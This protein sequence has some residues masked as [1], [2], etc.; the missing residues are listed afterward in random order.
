ML[1]DLIKDIPGINPCEIGEGRKHSYWLY[2]WSIDESKFGVSTAEFCAILG[3][4]GIPAGAGYIGKPIYDYEFLRDR[5]TY[6]NS[7]YPLQNVEY[8][9]D[10]CP[11]T[12]DILKRLITTPINEKYTE[13]D[14]LDIAAGIRKV[15]TA[16][17]K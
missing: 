8:K 4:E 9:L 6:G 3:K 15:A 1:T 5:N 7:H 11:N 17:A 14:V 2:P 13:Q 16:L 10:D 12:L